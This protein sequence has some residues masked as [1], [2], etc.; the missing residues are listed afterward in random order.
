MRKASR[1]LASANPANEITIA[2]NLNTRH[3]DAKGHGAA[4]RDGCGYIDSLCR[5]EQRF[6]NV[7]PDGDLFSSF[8]ITTPP[9]ICI[10]NYT[11]GR[12]AAS[13]IMLKMARDADGMRSIII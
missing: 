5:L 11:S 13:A 2:N 3:R 6:I 7:T 4:R 10:Y 8:L 12:C 9:A 1:R